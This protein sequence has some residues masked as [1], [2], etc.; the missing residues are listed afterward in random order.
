MSRL[1]SLD[2]R[3]FQPVDAERAAGTQG[4]SAAAPVWTRIPA[5]T[6]LG[7]GTVVVDYDIVDD[8]DQVTTANAIA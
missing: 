6:Y 4:G 2:A 5:N 7:D 3:L 8:S 1:E